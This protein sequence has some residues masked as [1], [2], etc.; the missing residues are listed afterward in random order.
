MPAFFRREGESEVPA[1]L[2]QPEYAYEEW[3][4]DDEQ[5]NKDGLSDDL[6]DFDRTRYSTD[7]DDS[8]SGEHRDSD[9][10]RVYGTREDNLLFRQPHVDEVILG[11]SRATTDYLPRGFWNFGEHGSDQSY[12]DT[13]DDSDEEEDGKHPLIIGSTTV[14]KPKKLPRFI[15]KKFRIFNEKFSSS[16]IRKG[17][18]YDEIV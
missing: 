6:D 13:G 12:E 9:F 16:F 11:Y 4:S 7:S 3:F 17:Y 1:E 8:D 5:S 10:H 15:A 18:G 14:G 2:A